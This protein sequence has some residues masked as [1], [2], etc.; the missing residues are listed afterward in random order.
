MQFTCNL[1]VGAIAIQLACARATV[2][3]HRPAQRTSVA[4]SG[5]NGGAVVAVVLLT[6][7]DP[8]Q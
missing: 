5:P 8:A 2:G 1:A 3:T 6:V 7:L 4:E